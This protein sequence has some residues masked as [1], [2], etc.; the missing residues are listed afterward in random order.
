MRAP[1]RAKRIITT[2]IRF[3]S[4]S[5]ALLRLLG[6]VPAGE[7]SVQ[8]HPAK[9]RA[10]QECLAAQD[11]T[12]KYRRKWAVEA[13]RRARGGFG[14]SRLNRF[15]RTEPIRAQTV[16]WFARRQ[17]PCE[18]WWALAFPVPA[19][20]KARREGWIHARAL[21]SASAAH[22]QSSCPP[23]GSESVSSASGLALAPFWFCAQSRWGRLCRR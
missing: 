3:L 22:R 17:R 4:A 15:L 6:V 1:K 10:G 21:S 19:V 5:C 18:L 12:P 11:T 13:N 8:A 16:R 2:A 20:E 7:L 23:Q 9:Q 14:A